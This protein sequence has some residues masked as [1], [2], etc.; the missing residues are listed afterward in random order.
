MGLMYDTAAV[1]FVPPENLA[2][3]T[4]YLDCRGD[5]FFVPAI[6]GAPMLKGLNLSCAKMRQGSIL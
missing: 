3:W 4:N 2:F 1:V 5:P 6:F